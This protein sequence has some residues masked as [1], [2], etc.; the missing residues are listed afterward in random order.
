MKQIF[1]KENIIT[2]VLVVLAC[3][4]AI[5][6]VVPMVGTLKSKLTPA[7]SPATAS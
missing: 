2:F 4:V 1:S 7:G 5:V 6:F 3:A